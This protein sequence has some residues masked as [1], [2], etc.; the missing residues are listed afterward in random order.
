MRIRKVLGNAIRHALSGS[1]LFDRNSF[2]RDQYE[3]VH[4][5][6]G[7]D[8]WIAHVTR[9]QMKTVI[10]YIATVS[11][12][13]TEWAAYNC[14]MSG[15][16]D[17][18]AIRSK[19]TMEALL[20]ELETASGVLCIVC[21]N[22]CS[23]MSFSGKFD[24]LLAHVYVKEAVKRMRR[25]K[26]RDSGRKKLYTFESYHLASFVRDIRTSQGRNADTLM[27]EAAARKLCDRV[28]GDYLN[29]PER[30]EVEFTDTRSLRRA[31]RAM[32]VVSDVMDGNIDF[33]IIDIHN[34]PRNEG[35]YDAL[36]LLHELAHVITRG[37]AGSCS[38]HGAQ[39]VAVYI[40]L[41]NRYLVHDIEKLEGEFKKH[42]IAYD[43]YSIFD[44]KNGCWL[45]EKRNKKPLKIRYASRSSRRTES[46]L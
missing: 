40:E 12:K 39:F 20:H 37:E 43:R 8:Y 17:I 38:P 42:K 9:E 3:V 26:D 31:G 45:H 15:T 16:N 29:E 35:R 21:D 27:S 25:E 2:P 10:P 22:S 32:T 28:L 33:A 18:F 13:G 23:Y 14:R 34:N 1:K 44:H 11:Y 30:I 36:T 41:L 24:F 6:G 46:G 19:W 5:A 4:N 7:A